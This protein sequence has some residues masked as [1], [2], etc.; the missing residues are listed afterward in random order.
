MPY[1]YRGRILHINLASGETWEERP[2][3]VFYRKYVGGRSLG[4]YYL[5]K[6]LPPGIDPLSP[7]NLLVLATSPTVGAPFPGNARHS[8]VAKSPLT[9]GFG[10][11][12]AGGFWGPELKKAGYDAVV[13]HG[14]A[15][16]PIYVVIDDG[17]V[18]LLSAQHLWGKG[19]QETR[20]LLQQHYDKAQVLCIGPAGEHLVR[21]ASI[22]AGPHDMHGR[23]G[24]GAVM[25]SKNLKAIVV[26]GTKAINLYDPETVKELAKWF[27]QHFKA[28]PT[29]RLLNETGTAGAVELYNELGSLPAFN[30][31]YGTIEGAEKLSGYTWRSKGLII[32]AHSCFACPVACRK[33]VRFESPFEKDRWITSHSAEYESLA[34]LGSN[35]GITE[36][37]EL[38]ALTALCDDLGLDTIS[39]GDVIAFLMECVE[40]KLLKGKMWEEL[41]KAKL[42][43]G[44]ASAAHWLIKKIAYREGVGRLA[45]E[46]VKK[47]CEMIGSAAKSFAMH[48]KGEEIALQEPRGQKIG[49]ALGYAVAPHGGDH[50]QMEHDYT[51]A[52]ESPFLQSMEPFGII[53]PIPPMD[54]GP[55]KVRLFVMNQILW[56]LYNVFDICIFVGP[57]GHTYR[58]DHLLTIIRAVTGWKTSWV[59]LFDIGRRSLTMARCFNLREGFSAKDDWLP[60]RFF[61]PLKGGASAGNSVPRKELKRAVKIYYSLM[62]WNPI[63]GVPTEATLYYLDLDWLLDDPKIRDLVTRR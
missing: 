25:G 21:Y 15:K 29:N 33:T 54:L 14:A 18:E 12:E 16:Q 6:F 37:R 57:P 20:E 51:F 32:G 1:G 11:S 36:E 63:N 59:E 27:A 61:E 41:Q 40:R 55:K 22:S 48:V 62:G 3:E 52:T 30:F 45:A 8:V 35:C 43:F 7:E 4:L 19:T 50:I 31:R 34:A 46:G 47:L 24:L 5:L 53:E 23:M 9:L 17:D 44:N 13:I 58:P 2:T 56:S 42:T 49:A 39:T 28:D 26:R 38:L 60:D 10:E